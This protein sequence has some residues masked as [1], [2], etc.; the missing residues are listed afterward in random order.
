MSRHRHIPTPA[1]LRAMAQGAL[2]GARLA[3]GPARWC[4]L[5]GFFDLAGPLL[6]GWIMLPLALL[7]LP[8]FQQLVGG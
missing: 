5:R 3:V 7:A 8:Y 6:L 4:E 1:E 2:V